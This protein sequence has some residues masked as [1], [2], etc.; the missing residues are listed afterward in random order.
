VSAPCLLD[1]GVLVA[2]FWPRHTAHDAARKW[3][4]SHRKHGWAT[5]ALTESGFVR[6]VSNAAVSHGRVRPEDAVRLPEENCKDGH[7]EFWPLDLPLADA[8]RRAG[9]Q[10]DGHYQVPGAYLLGLAAKHGGRLATFDTR[11]GRLS[12]PVLTL[13]A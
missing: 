8:L 5:C 2:I 1:L 11:L 13:R 12:R 4:A 6:V 3:F 10:L 7:H 9:V